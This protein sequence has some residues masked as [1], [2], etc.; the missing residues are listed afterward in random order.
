MLNAM[1]KVSKE[2]RSVDI[3]N[4]DIADIVLRYSWR[5]FG[6]R[7]HNTLFCTYVIYLAVFVTAV[8]SFDHLLQTFAGSVVAWL[9]Q[10]AVLAFQ[11]YFIRGEYK[12]YISNGRVFL[13]IWILM[14]E[15][16]WNNVD[17]NVITFTT[18][19]MLVRICAGKETVLSR[20]LLAFA[21]ILSWQKV[22]YFLRPYKLS[23]PLG[24]IF[25]LI[26]S[27]MFCYVI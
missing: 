3:F 9:L 18:A 7:V 16:Y 11:I 4:S 22:L 6:M 15:D 5:K 13:R 14:G 27:F 10:A 8:Y 26:R 17:I 19:G 24:N 2:L 23:G 20:C 1:V 25:L 21:S 12:Q